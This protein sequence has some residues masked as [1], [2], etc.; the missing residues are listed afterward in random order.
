MLIPAFIFLASL[1]VFLPALRNGF[2]NWDD[3]LTISLNEHIRGLSWPH[4]CWMFALPQGNAGQYHPLTWLSFALDY[5]LW[6]AAPFG[7]HLTSLLLHAV[8]AVLFY[9][10][11]LKLFACASGESGA[12]RDSR[13]AAAFAALLFGLHP[14]RVESVVW[15]TER[16]GLLSGLF[17]LGTLLCYLKAKT[18]SAASTDRR[19]TAAAWAAYL[20]SL[21][22][23][24]TGITLP[25]ILLV[26]DCYPLR[27][28]SAL[29]ARWLRAPERGVILEKLVF[30]APA[31]G[32][33]TINLFAELS[34]GAGVPRAAGT[35]GLHLAVAVY[36]LTFYLWKMLLPVHLLPLYSMPATFGGLGMQFWLSA[37]VAVG[38]S[39]VLFL[40]RRRWPAGLAAGTIYVL[41][42]LPVLGL[43]QVGHHMVADRYSY[44][45]NLGWAALAGA[46]L[47]HFLRGGRRRL[48]LSGAAALAVLL[49]AMT[50]RQT[51]V[52]RDSESLWR[53]AVAQ[54]PNDAIVL[55]NLGVSLIAKGK[56]A[57]AVAYLQTLVRIQ[58]DQESARYNLAIALDLLP[59]LEGA[60][61]QYHEV[62]RINPDNITARLN[63]GTDL[64]KLNRRA[65]AA[66][67][68]RRLVQSHPDYVPAYFNLGLI[69]A[70]SGQFDEAARQFQRALELQPESLELRFQL[71]LTLAKS[72]RFSEA[73]RHFREILRVDPGNA[74]ARRNLELASALHDQSRAG[75]RGRTKAESSSMRQ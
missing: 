12:D 43:V 46:A 44:L 33:A 75:A 9:F 49:G 8:N 25:A 29:P 73:I 66:Q 57:E 20:L 27:R 18:A 16:R 42:L 70:D 35:I 62:L 31:V 4:L 3:E 41:T 22:A 37:A 56:N 53:H 64:Y 50:W 32:I 36:G 67:E 39:L 58:P 68:M 74:L 72:G 7:Y 5:S 60:L 10:L 59:D 26:L 23:K 13:T 34:S 51:Q 17:Y 61:R 11:S 69:L 45:A 52:W 14:L 65:D 21:L 63:L 2:V 55:Y 54:R 19:W 15:A 6:G 38:I 28:L 1:A 48:I 40:A 24:G 71:G 47:R 30:A